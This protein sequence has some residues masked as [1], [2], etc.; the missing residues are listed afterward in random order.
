MGLARS[1]DL[2]TPPN[3]QPSP[4]VGTDSF[5]ISRLAFQM[6]GRTELAFLLHCFPRLEV[7]LQQICEA[8]PENTLHYTL[9]F[10]YKGHCEIGNLV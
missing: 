2:I 10:F 1:L 3:G 4:S 6:E 9:Y 7:D 8:G 5:C